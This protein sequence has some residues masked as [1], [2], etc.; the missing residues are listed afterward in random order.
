[1]TLRRIATVSI[2]LVFWTWNLCLVALLGIGLGLFALPEMIMAAT[3]GMMAWQPVAWVSILVATPVLFGIAGFRV[4]HDPGRLATMFLGVELPFMA[5][6]TVR[7][8]GIVDPGPTVQLLT[9]FWLLGT[10][11]LLATI[12]WG[13]PREHTPTVLPRLLGHM[14]LGASGLWLAAVTAPVL[15]PLAVRTPM[16][17]VEGITEMARHSR[18]EDLLFMAFYLP[19]VLATGAALFAA[20]IAMVGISLGT[21]RDMA[22]AAARTVGQTRTGA[23]L[24]AGLLAILGSALVAT[25]ARPDPEE[26]RSV[27]QVEAD[28]DRRR[29]LARRESVREGAVDLYLSEE[30]YL[31]TANISGAYGPLDTTLGVAM[32]TFWHAVFSPVSTGEH[33]GLGWRRAHRAEARRLY[34][35][36]FDQ[37]LEIAEA[38]ALREANANQ[39]DWR[40]AAAGLDTIDQ[41]RVWLAHQDVTVEPHGDHATVWIHDTYRNTTFDNHEVA[42]SFTLPPTAVISG[43]WLSD[44][45]DR[46]KAHGHIVAPRGAAQEVY[47]RE[48]R[49]SIDPAL[50]EQVG[51]RQY[52]V[53]AFPVIARQGDLDSPMDVEGQGVPLHL[54]IRLEVLADSDGAWP[55]PELT[56]VRNLFWTEDTVRTLQEQP[57]PALSTWT[58]ASLPGAG[59]RQTHHVAIDATTSLVLRP[60]APPSLPA[61]RRFALVDNSLSMERHRV[62]IAQATQALREAGIS[63]LCVREAVV[64][65]CPDFDAS[66]HLFWGGHALSHQLEDAAQ[67]VAE[68]DA[69]IVLTDAGSYE[70]EPDSADLD[71]LPTTWLVHL[72]GHPHAYPDTVGDLLART[73]GGAADTVAEAL[74]GLASDARWHDG[75]TWS[76]SRTPAQDSTLSP[77]AA[78]LAIR[79]AAREG[80]ALE[81]LDALHR[82]AVTHEVVSTWSSMMVPVTEAQREALRAASEG[83]DRFDRE[84]VDGLGDELTATPEPGAILL[85]L[86]GLGVSRTRRGIT[87]VGNR[88]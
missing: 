69:L 39:F 58:P 81:Q 45:G 23:T 54:W 50:I 61:G 5:I 46:S 42:I 25:Q 27:V 20:P 55:M 1:M 51:P 84:I 18:G 82:W 26:A 73:G 13:Y 48:V 80:D 67:H 78:G 7:V 38:D 11:S 75:W 53:R 3:I 59:T 9:T 60:A 62:A 83:D 21:T 16:A 56:Q 74:A 76:L 85:L 66:S 88:P 12:L 64:V 68:A 52:R 36:M 79:L 31:P 15:L 77:L 17:I 8:F 35:A 6:V 37:P 33:D 32:N 34:A 2:H 71:R 65:P 63:L 30:R 4:R 29:L 28:E 41:H 22:R 24:V 72:G 44:Q 49:R 57:T 40:S 43:L 47:E 86:L 19:F 14:A 10:T 70:L 87:V